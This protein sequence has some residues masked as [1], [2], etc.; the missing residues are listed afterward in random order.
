MDA[1][2]KKT[3]AKEKILRVWHI[4]QVPGKAF[5]VPVKSPREGALLLKVLASYDIFQFEN[6]IK[7]DFC[8]AGGLEV[9]E[10]GVWCEWEDESGLS[11]DEVSGT[12]LGI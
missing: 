8:N 5:H 12:L 2:P 7:P 10:D 6:R 1:M 3:E 4:P 9:C 11:I